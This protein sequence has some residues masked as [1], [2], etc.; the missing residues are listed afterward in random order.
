MWPGDVESQ[1]RLLYYSKVDQEL[2]AIA[3][4]ESG[5]LF[6]VDRAYLTENGKHK[7]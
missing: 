2:T 7:R 3:F 6:K 1:L 5:M 4:S